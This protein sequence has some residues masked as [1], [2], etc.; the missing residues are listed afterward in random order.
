MTGVPGKD[1][2][3]GRPGPTGAAGLVGESGTQGLRGDTGATGDTGP[4]GENG[5]AGD[6]GATGAT[7]PTGEKGETGMNGQPGK[8]YSAVVVGGS[9][10]GPHAGFDSVRR[11]GEGE[12]C[13]KPESGV[14]YY[15]PVA[16]PEWIGSTGNY[17]QVEPIGRENDYSCE[18]GEFAVFTFL[19]E[20]GVA[21]R[22][23][24]VNFIIALPQP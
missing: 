10:S 20:S 7:G 23:N 5:S 15:Y 24:G 16:S 22:S 12:Y 8:S 11:T 13:L 14:N 17:L 19:L 21:V 6:T 4:T 1:G 18:E 9:F 2:A 3:G